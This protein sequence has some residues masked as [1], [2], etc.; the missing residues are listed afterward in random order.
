MARPSADPTQPDPGE[1]ALRAFVRA[2]AAGDRDAMTRAWHAFVATEWARIKGMVATWRHSALPDSRVPAD[3]HEDVVVDAV[4]RLLPYLEL[5]GSSVGEAKNMV[6][7]HTEFAL[8]D[9]V[10]DHTKDDMHRAG[11]LDESAPDG[12]GPG[13]AAVRAETEAAG[14]RIDGI[15]QAELQETFLNALR[16]VD[17][18]KR[19]V[20]ALRILRGLSGDEVAE[21]LGLTRANVD[22]LNSRGLAQ[23]RDALRDGP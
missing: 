2:R 9:Y 3:A 12:E 22:Q 11:S 10:R 17:E 13:S 15:D 16:A 6:R 4:A 20:L 1:V 21:R 14:L 8:L 7:R 19:A 23:V 5:R 18:N